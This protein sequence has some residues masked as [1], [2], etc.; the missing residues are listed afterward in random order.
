MVGGVEASVPEAR[1]GSTN[2]DCHLQG[3]VIDRR[4]VIPGNVLPVQGPA[5]QPWPRTTLDFSR[6]TN[7]KNGEISA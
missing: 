7:G 4:S 2:R 6:L 5:T 3:A 1:A